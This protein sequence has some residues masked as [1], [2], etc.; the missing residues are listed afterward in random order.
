MRITL[1]S[2][3]KVVEVNG[4]PARIWEGATESGIPIHVYVT[5]VAVEEQ[6][7]HHE[8]FERQLQTHRAPSPAVQAISLRLV[9]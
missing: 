4:V 5:R 3:T 7:K 9:L 6:Q 2:T 8:E 1:E